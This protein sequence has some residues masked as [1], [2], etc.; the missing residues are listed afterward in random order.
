[1]VAN[2]PALL[3]ICFK[4]WI[5]TRAGYRNGYHFRQL[6]S[7][8]GPLTLLVPQFRDGTFSTEIFQRY[9]RSEQA[10]VWRCRRSI[11]DA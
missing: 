6:Y 10:L 2:W 5:L 3:S 4:R 9:Q 11:G 1:M 8:V 7:H